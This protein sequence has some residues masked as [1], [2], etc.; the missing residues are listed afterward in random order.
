MRY[1]KSTCAHIKKLREKVTKQL[2]VDSDRTRIE[3]RMAM[4]HENYRITREQSLK[5]ILPAP[6]E[7]PA[8]AG[9]RVEAAKALVMLDIAVFK[10]SQRPACSRSPSRR[11]PR[12][13][14]TTRCRLTSAS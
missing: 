3:D 7:K 5:I 10:P 2:I 11:S 8:K 14:S 13:S 6:G 9:D 1:N 4:T 12:T